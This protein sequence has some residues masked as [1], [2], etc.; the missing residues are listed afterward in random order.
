VLIEAK[1]E[2][3]H[4]HFTDWVMRELAVWCPKERYP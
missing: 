1:D 4:G 3:E 2:L